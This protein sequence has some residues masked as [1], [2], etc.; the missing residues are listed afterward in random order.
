MSK[1]LKISIAILCFIILLFLVPYLIAVYDSQQIKVFMGGKEFLVSV[2]DTNAERTK[3]LSGT[4][5]IKDNEGMLFVFPEK[6]SYGFWMKDMLYNLD[7]IWI[8]ENL[9]ITHI[10]KSLSPD[11][12]PKVFYPTKPSLYV[13][14]VLAG[15]SENLK[16]IIGDSL[17]FSKK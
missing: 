16:L 10:E 5:Q 13:L 12:Y 6:G 4:S 15:Q 7:I 14:E 9:H 8:D 17:I 3:G 1:L 11:S 2:A